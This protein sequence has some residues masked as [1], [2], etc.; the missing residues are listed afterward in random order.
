MLCYWNPMGKVSK[1]SMRK[2]WKKM[3]IEMSYTLLALKETIILEKFIGLIIIIWDI[4][5]KIY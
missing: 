4:N 3:I 1:N 5:Q 2:I